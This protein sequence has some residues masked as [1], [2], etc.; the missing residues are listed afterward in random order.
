M[1][2]IS[3]ETEVEAEHLG[4]TRVKGLERLADRLAQK[5]ILDFELRF[6][7]FFR[8]EPLDELRVFAVADGRIKTDLGCIQRLERLYSSGVR[9]VASLNS[10]GAGSRPSSCLRRSFSRKMRA[11]SLARLSGTR[12]ARPWLANDARIA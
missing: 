7:R 6:S 12:T 5:S 2:P 8:D 10:S 9:S 1:L 3:L 11:R 4:I